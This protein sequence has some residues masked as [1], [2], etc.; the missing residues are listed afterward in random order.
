MIP[1]IKIKIIKSALSPYEH[2]CIGYPQK[3]GY[4]TALIMGIGV[5]KK[6]FAHPGSFVLDSIIA[7]DK[8]E[9]EQAYLGQI[10][11]EIVSSF[12]GPEGLIWGY[13]VAREESFKQL[14]FLDKKDLKNFKKIKI[15]NGENLRKAAIEL[16]GTKNNLHFPF[17]PG[18][19]VPCAGRFFLRR[20]LLLFI[21]Q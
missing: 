13:D 12:C 16:F 6:V 4:F 5:T 15:L 19:H 3:G 8:A 1:F 11:M 9:I 20:V 14:K 18:T 10:N 2:Y 21:P 17:L 7:F